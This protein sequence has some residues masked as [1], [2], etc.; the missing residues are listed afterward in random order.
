MPLDVFAFGLYI[1]VFANTIFVKIACVVAKALWASMF[2]MNGWFLHSPT[3]VLNMVTSLYM[4]LSREHV[5][6]R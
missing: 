2:V 4:P 5:D 1:H 6:F 3:F